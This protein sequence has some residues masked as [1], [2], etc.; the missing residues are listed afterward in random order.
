MKR[1]TSWYYTHT[2]GISIDE[3]P[4]TLESIGCQCAFAEAKATHIPEKNYLILFCAEGRG[5]IE[6]ADHIF[7]AEKGSVICFCSDQNETALIQLSA[8]CICFSISFQTNMHYYRKMLNPPCHFL[9]GKQDADKLEAHIDELYK[10]IAF[11]IGEKETAINLIITQI[12]TLLVN[13]KQGEILFNLHPR[14]VDTYHYRRPTLPGLSGTFPQK[15]NEINKVLLYIHGQY[16]N[17]ITLDE[18]SRMIH[19]NKCYFVK[20]FRSLVGV[21]PYEYI[22]N[23]RVNEA[24]NLLITTELSVNEIA[25]LT[26]FLD[27]NNFIRRFRSRANMTPLQYRNQYRE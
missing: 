11:E 22:I 19:F 16:K 20:L 23:L 15:R 8:D 17:K 27:T 2:S 26:G 21:S 5:I 12:M 14:T 9:L 18:L 4:F 7:S 10:I 25:S 1:Y 24:K 6:Y 3:L 13:K